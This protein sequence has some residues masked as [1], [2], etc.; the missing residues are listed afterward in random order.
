MPV[1]RFEEHKIIIL[2]GVLRHLN[3]FNLTNCKHG[4]SFSSKSTDCGNLVYKVRLYPERSRSVGFE[5]VDKN[6]SLTG[7][8]LMCTI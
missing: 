2:F 1:Q 8:R 3:L 6:V 4:I 7:Q 5:E